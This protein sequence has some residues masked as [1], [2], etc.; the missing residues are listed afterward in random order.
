MSRALVV[1][2]FTFGCGGPTVE[3]VAGERVTIA[4]GL[5][6]QV[7]YL[8]DVGS[9]TPRPVSGEAIEVLDRP[10][11]SVVTNGVSDSVGAFQIELPVGSH[12]LCVDNICITFD[13]QVDELVRADFRTGFDTFWTLEQPSYCSSTSG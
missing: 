12:A 9:R 3:C 7:T 10:Q 1:L 8:S 5:Y 4:Q 6:G 2:G 11:G 13:I